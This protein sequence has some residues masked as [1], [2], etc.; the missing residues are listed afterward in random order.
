ML[1]ALLAL[2]LLLVAAW[3][4]FVVS[5]KCDDV[6][7]LVVVNEVVVFVDSKTM[8][9]LMRLL[10]DCPRCPGAP[11]LA[12]IRMGLESLRVPLM[13]DNNSSS[14]GLTPAKS[15]EDSA[16][17]LLLS[18]TLKGAADDVVCSN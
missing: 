11:A 8:P 6:V 14:N 9:A 12:P 13:R 3:L 18:R 15:S 10:G 4:V 17:R 16:S 5:A 1:S 2:L 7:L